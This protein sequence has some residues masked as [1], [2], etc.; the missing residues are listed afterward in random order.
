MI[1]LT[2]N[3]VSDIS[4]SIVLAL[5]FIFSSCVLFLSCRK[6]LGN[7]SVRIKH[8]GKWNPPT[9]VQISHAVRH[10]GGCKK[11]NALFKGCSTLVAMVTTTDVRDL[12]PHFHTKTSQKKSEMFISPF[13]AR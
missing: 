1:R 12:G 10:S 11:K 4:F 9:P 7:K 6:C 3:V 8:L 13:Q 5:N 2:E